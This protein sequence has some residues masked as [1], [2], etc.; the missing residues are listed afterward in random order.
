ML[1]A[2]AFTYAHDKCGGTTKL[3]VLHVH[4]ALAPCAQWSGQHDCG[5]CTVGR[6]KHKPWGICLKHVHSLA[7]VNILQEALV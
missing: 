1:Y 3:C 6:T 2:K 4:A 7:I 5:L